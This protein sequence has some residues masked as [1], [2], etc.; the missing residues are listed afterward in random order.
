M[1]GTGQ[2]YNILVFKKDELSSK[3]VESVVFSYLSWCICEDCFQLHICCT[4]E[5]L[6]RSI[7]TVLISIL[8]FLDNSGVK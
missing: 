4:G 7:T 6:S 1:S 8:A 5:Y 2:G 3:T